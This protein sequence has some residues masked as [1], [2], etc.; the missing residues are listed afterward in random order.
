LL[1]TAA[2]FLK[3]PELLAALFFN[4]KSKIVVAVFKLYLFHNHQ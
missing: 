2:G 4:D 1:Q 3:K